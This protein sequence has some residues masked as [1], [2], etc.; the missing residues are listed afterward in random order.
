MKVGC[1]SGGTSEENLMLKSRCGVYNIDGDAP[2]TV[3]GKG[4]DLEDSLRKRKL[5]R[6]MASAWML[7]TGH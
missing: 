1:Q 5:V 3:P 2:A 6:S 7:I 4:W